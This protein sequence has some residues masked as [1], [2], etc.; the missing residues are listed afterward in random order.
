MG[1][2]CNRTAEVRGSI[3]LG[4]TRFPQGAKNPTPRPQL[5]QPQC[6]AH[7]APIHQLEVLL[8]GAIVRVVHGER[9]FGER[10]D[11]AAPGGEAIGAGDGLDRPALPGEAALSSEERRVGTECVTK[12]RFGWWLLNSQKQ[13]EPYTILS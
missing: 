4:S 3:P 11:W 7:L 12:C 6:A 13:S 9:A 10:A 5:L 1:E 8:P 2:R